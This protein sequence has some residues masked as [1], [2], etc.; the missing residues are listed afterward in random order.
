[1]DSPQLSLSELQG[2]IKNAMELALPDS[3]WVRA[4][5]SELTVNR[6]G[7]CYLDLIETDSANNITARV[8]ATIWSYT[9]RMLKPYFEST[10]GQL[11]SEGIKVLLNAKVEYHEVYGLSLNVRDIDPTYTLGDMAQQRRVIIA[12]LE[13]EGI[14]D[15]NKELELPLVPQRVAII[16]SPTA[17]GLQDFIDQ[18]HNNPQRIKFYT[19]LFPAVM[20]GKEAPASIIQ[21][22][23][24]IFEYE[25][26]FDAV[27]IIRGGGAQVDLVAFDNYDLA[28][29]ITQFPLPVITGIGHDKDDSVAD[30]VAHTRLKTPT[31]VAEF[32]I[33]TVE[34]FTSYLAELEQQFVDA[35]ND[36]LQENREQL[37]NLLNSISGLARMRIKDEQQLLQISELKLKTGLESY[38]QE[39]KNAFH[40]LASEIKSSTGIFIRHRQNLLARSVE[41]TR[42]STKTINWKKGN[43]LKT[44]RHELKYKV[45]DKLKFENQQMLRL[46]ETLRLVDPQQIL[47]RGF[48]LTYKNGKLLKSVEQLAKGDRIETRLADGTLESNIQLITQNS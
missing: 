17:A 43:E 1:M 10:T 12:R 47:K 2:M 30:L 48:S 7:H 8:R 16:S 39:K 21:A 20:Q 33:S 42:F 23:D 35:V 19:K 13:E 41:K 14:F 38:F 31:A 24:R 45:E 22:L 9:F 34:E 40:L 27:A 32:L 29:H 18:L 25:E 44:I 11:F 36:R 3:Y 46:Q 4:E 37:N 5:I 28:F 26:F 6:S 15:M